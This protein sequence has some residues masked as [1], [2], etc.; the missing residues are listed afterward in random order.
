ML[1][2]TRKIGQQIILPEQ[3]ITIDILQGGCTRVR[4]GISA[5]AGVPIHR[6]EVWDRVQ[7]KDDRQPSSSDNPP[8]RLTDDSESS[9]VP[10]PSLADL[11][12]CLQW[13]TK[14]TAGRLS[15]LSVE[16][17]GGRIVIRGSARSYY[18]RQL[19]QAAVN[20]V[21]S[22]C[23]DLS[24]GSVDCRIDVGQFYWRSAGCAQALTRLPGE[25]R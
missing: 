25:P 13:I 7:D 3:G 16:K 1:V 14:R 12:Q 11:D 21:L 5:P 17:H 9:A 10:S 18:V 8:D 22:F 19:A 6:R 15:R 4:L 24:P 23:R 20:E 2:L